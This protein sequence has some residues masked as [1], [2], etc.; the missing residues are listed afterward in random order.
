MV[1]NKLFIVVSISLENVNPTKSIKEAKF[2]RKAKST[3]VPP[4]KVKGDPSH[5]NID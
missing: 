4:P 1:P 3:M 2:Y 5:Q